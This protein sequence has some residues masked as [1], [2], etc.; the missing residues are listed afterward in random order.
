MNFSIYLPEVHVK[1]FT[2]C[3]HTL[4]S[5]F[6]F[7]GKPAA[8]FLESSYAVSTSLPSRIDSKRGSFVTKDF[9]DLN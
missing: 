9:E 5:V 7:A 4:F 6:G 3:Y 8:C 1:R 2:Y